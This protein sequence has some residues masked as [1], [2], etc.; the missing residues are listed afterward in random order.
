MIAPEFIVWKDKARIPVFGR[1]RTELQCVEG[2]GQNSNVRILMFATIRPEFE[3]FRIA[4][5][6]RVR[7]EF[8]SCKG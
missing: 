8:Q 7:S 2:N 3:C 4:V 6:G 5:F 1:I